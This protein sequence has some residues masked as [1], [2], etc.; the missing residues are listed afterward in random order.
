VCLVSGVEPVA[1]DQERG[2]WWLG[3]EQ[4]ATPEQT[5]ALF[6]LPPLRSLTPIPSHQVL[7]LT[8]TQLQEVTP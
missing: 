4:C 2:V 7:D 1:N 6:C 8:S 3:L 5:V